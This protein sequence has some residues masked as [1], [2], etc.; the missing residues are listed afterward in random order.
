M[1]GHLV[2]AAHFCASSAHTVRIGRI[3][4]A[5]DPAKPVVVLTNSSDQPCQVVTGSGL[6]T[7]AFTSVLQDGKAIEPLPIDVSFSEVWSCS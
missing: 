4:R 6:G 7:V 2:L 5:T 1:F 3:V